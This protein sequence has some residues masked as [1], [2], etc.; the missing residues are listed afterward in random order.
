MRVF[1]ILFAFFI[2]SCADR[3]EI[4]TQDI[5][6]VT[7][8]DEIIHDFTMLSTIGEMQEWFMKADYFE[9]FSKERRWMAFNV[10]L[11]TLNETDKNFYRSDSLFVS[12]I[13]DVYTGMGNV[14]I[15]SPN[16]ILHTDKIIWDRRTDRIH[17]PND[18][19]IK[20]DNN[21]IWGSVLYTNSNMD[22][23]D[24]RHVSGIGSV[25]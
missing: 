15:I 3:A 9:R 24:L 7:E 19:Y 2:F 22:F 6:R 18:V 1:F 20:N 5:E 13:T 23:V 14:E 17:A 4:S 11:E 10:F 21:E 16:G 8:A 25:E 12:E